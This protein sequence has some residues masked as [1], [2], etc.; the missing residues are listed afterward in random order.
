VVRDLQAELVASCVAVGCAY[1]VLSD[2]QVANFEREILD[3]FGFRHGAP[4]WE[5]LEA[6]SS[7]WD[8]HVWTSIASLVPKRPELI[9]IAQVRTTT[10]TG[11]QLHDGDRLQDVLDDS[12]RFVFYVTDADVSFVVCANDHDMVISCGA[13]AVE[14]AEATPDDA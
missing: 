4:L 9:L 2:E 10:L 6:G 14:L 11:L 13:D 3:K 5:Q 1:S 12:Y 7:R 8:P